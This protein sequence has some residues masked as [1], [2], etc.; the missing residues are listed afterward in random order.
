MI[1]ASTDLPHP[2]P[3]TIETISPSAISK[4]TPSTARTSFFPLPK[5]RTMSLAEKIGVS[6]GIIT[7]HQ[8][9]GQGSQFLL[10]ETAFGSGH[11]APFREAASHD[12]LGERRRCPFDGNG[13]A[14]LLARFGGKHGAHERPSVGVP[15]I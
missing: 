5:V 6:F 2:D 3:P 8:S 7:P 9:V 12:F 10:L 4:L 13:L 1:L 15:R 14:V 11:G